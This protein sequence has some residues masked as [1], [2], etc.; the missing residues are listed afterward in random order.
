[1]YIYTYTEMTFQNVGRWHFRM[2]ERPPRWRCSAVSCQRT[3]ARPMTIPAS[4]GSLFFL[5]SFLHF[6][7]FL[8]EDKGTSNDNTRVKRFLFFFFLSFFFS[9]FIFF[10]PEGKGASNDFARRQVVPFFFD[11]FFFYPRQGHVQRCCPRRAVDR[12]VHDQ[13][14]YVYVCVYVYLYTI[15][16]YMWMYMYM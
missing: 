6:L 16:V 8:P 5:F 3:R 15:N 1:M 14:V 9:Q 4:S 13:C 11:L 12:Q 10:L 7:F 2:C